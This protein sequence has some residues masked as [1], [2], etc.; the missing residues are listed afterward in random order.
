MRLIIQLNF[1]QFLLIW[2][3]FISFVYT[4]SFYILSRT[5]SCI[6]YMKGGE[7]VAIGNLSPYLTSKVADKR[8]IQPLSIHFR[9]WFIISV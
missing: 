2:F 3:I 6:L 4:Y 8:K 5:L 7:Y 9:D 1:W